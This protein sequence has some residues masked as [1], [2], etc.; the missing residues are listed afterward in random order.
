MADSSDPGRAD[1]YRTLREELLQAKKYVFERPLL[2]VALGVAGLRTLEDNYIALLPVIVA[3]LLLFNFWFTANRL[4]SA[5]R[6]AAYIQLELEERTHGKWKGWETCLR[7]YRRWIKH[8]P[9][10]KK[11]DVDEEL[12]KDVI[13]D[14]LMYYSAIYRLH[15]GLMLFTLSGSLFLLFR[16]GHALTMGCSV[17]VI[18]LLAWFIAQLVRYRPS[19]MSPLIERNR[20]IWLH[21]FAEMQKRDLGKALLVRKD[22]VK[23]DPALQDVNRGARKLLATAILDT[24]ERPSTEVEWQPPRESEKC[25]VQLTSDTELAVFNN[26]AE[27]DRHLHRKGTEIYTVLEGIMFIEIEGEEHKLEQGDLIVLNPNTLHQVQKETEFLC[28]VLIAN[29]GGAKDK[30]AKEYSS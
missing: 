1:E 27:Q 29:S 30:Y 11:D 9:I 18:L 24:K 23:E 4:F 20:A 10:K 7:E 21:V 2:I 26:L 14:A 28:Q 12:D 5:A 25:A 22:L 19:V 8:E 6:I 3:A 15:I 17:L 16:D 13:P